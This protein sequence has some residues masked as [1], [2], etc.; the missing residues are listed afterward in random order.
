MPELQ[1]TITWPL[2]SGHGV[3]LMSGIVLCLDYLSFQQCYNTLPLQNKTKDCDTFIYWTRQFPYSLHLDDCRFVGPTKLYANKFTYGRTIVQRRVVLFFTHL[4]FCFFY[5]IFCFCA[6][7]FSFFFEMFFF[8]FHF[9]AFNYT[10]LQR[11]ANL[12]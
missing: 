12:S 6:Y 11:M 5:F 10:V 9:T 7:L 3:H 1:L 8:C 2:F 4:L